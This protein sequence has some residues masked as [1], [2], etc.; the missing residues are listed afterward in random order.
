MP[1]MQN[2]HRRRPKLKLKGP[3]NSI[4]SY[5]EIHS[6]N[7]AEK[8]IGC[9]KTPRRTIANVKAR[10]HQKTRA[11]SKRSRVRYMCLKPIL[12][13]FRGDVK[14]LPQSGSTPYP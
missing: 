3:F 14:T 13:V 4:K 6:E 7:P 9:R 11:Y 2:T 5:W 10:L 12:G 8:N 1:G